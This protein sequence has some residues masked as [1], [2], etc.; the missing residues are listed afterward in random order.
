V[1]GWNPIR[2]GE[3]LLDDRPGLG[4]DLDDAALAAH[5]YVANPFPSLWDDR[6]LTDFT[7]NRR[8]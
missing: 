3:L 8:T 4:I 6:W 7:Q 2:N 1:R 5:P